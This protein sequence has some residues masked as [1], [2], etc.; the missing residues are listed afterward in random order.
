MNCALL[1]FRRSYSRTK[2][3]RLPS[4]HAIRMRF[5][6]ESLLAPL[7]HADARSPPQDQFCCVRLFPARL[8][9]GR[10]AG[11]MRPNVKRRSRRPRRFVFNRASERQLLA[12]GFGKPSCDLFPAHDVEESGDVIRTPILVIEVI[13][14]F[15]NVDAQNGDSTVHEWTILV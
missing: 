1:A 2:R 15:P 8:N 13:C 7:Q 5:F 11:F 14:V 9:R 3:P 6:N 10:D 12:F 4:A